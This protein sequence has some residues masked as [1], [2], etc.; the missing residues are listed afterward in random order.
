MNTIASEPRKKKYKRKRIKTSRHTYTE[1]SRKRADVV[2]NIKEKESNNGEGAAAGTEGTREELLG[3]V[4][5]SQSSATNDKES[6]LKSLFTWL[7]K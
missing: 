4:D 7:R 6:T 5:S 2:H 1:T 3:T